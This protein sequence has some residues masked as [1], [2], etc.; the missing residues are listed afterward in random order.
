MLRKTR[1][2]EISWYGYK[3]E[4]WGMPKVIKISVSWLYQC[5]QPGSDTVLQYHK[6]LLL[7]REN[8][9]RVHKMSLSFFLK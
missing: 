6:V 1:G 7:S 4:P 8:G 3:I 9:Y 2:W 5:Q